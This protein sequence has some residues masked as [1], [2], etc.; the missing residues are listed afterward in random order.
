MKSIKRTL[1]VESRLAWALLWIGVV[2]FLGALLWGMLNPHFSMM[3][4]TGQRVTNETAGASEAAQTGWDR[5]TW[6][7]EYWP[8]WSGMGLLYYGYRRALNE[9]KRTP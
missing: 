6:V 8:L 5:I 1:T 2:V 4:D 3:K 9:S 7:W